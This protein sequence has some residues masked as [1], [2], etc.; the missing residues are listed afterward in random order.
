MVNTVPVYEG[1]VIDVMVGFART[2]RHCGVDADPDR[3]HSMVRAL[4]ELDVLNRADAYW[5]GRL[6]LCADP[7]DLDRYDAAFALYFSGKHARLMAAAAASVARSAQW[8]GP[9]AEGQPLAGQPAAGASRREV[10]RHLDFAALSAGERAELQRL[11]TLLAPTVSGRR[12]HR[13]RPATRGSVDLPRSLRRMLRAGGEPTELAHRQRREKPRRLVVLI[14]VSGSMAP[15]SDAML[16]FGHAAVR[17]APAGAEVFTLGTRLTRVTR[18]LRLR[19]PDQALA[20]AGRAVPDWS[21]GTRL[22]DTVKAF[23]DRWGQPG[24]ARGAVL[25]ICSDG[26]ER[27]DPAELGDQLARLAR[28][29]HA[30]VWVNPHKGKDGFAPATRGMVAAL[31]HLDALVAGHS[32]AALEELVKVLADA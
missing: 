20:A 29:A 24:L 32:F 12:S 27:G 23:T 10:L 16:R 8:E 31:P 17:C 15:Y 18:Q 28:L 25:V 30:L 21:G 2:L 6:T 11:F 3:V 7:A 9:G 13:H 14:D 1:D 26:W 19:D 5:A 22:G 4:A